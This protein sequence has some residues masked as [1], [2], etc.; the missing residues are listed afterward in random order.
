MGR[1]LLVPLLAY[2]GCG[3]PLA[4]AGP[5]W[6]IGQIATRYEAFYPAAGDPRPGQDAGLLRPRFGLPAIAQ[7][8]ASFTIELLERG[9]PIVAHAALLRPDVSSADAERCLAGT[10][11]DGCHPLNLRPD[12]SRRLDGLSVTR[13]RAQATAPPGG[14]DLYLHPRCDAPTRAPRA[15]WLRTEDPARLARVRVVQLSD[16]HI[17][18]H[19]PLVEQ[20]LRQVIGEVNALAP[21]LVVVTGDIVNQGTD[22]TLPPHARQLLERISAPVAIVLGNH[23]IGFHTWVGARYGAGWEN[24]ARSFHPFLEFELSLGGYRFVG[25]D[26]GATTL[27][28][29]IM[30]R[31]LSP[32]TLTRLRRALETAAQEGAR[33]VVLFSHAPSRAVLSGRVSAAHG[34]L[35]G[36][37]RDGRRTFEQLLLRSA[38]QGERVL[39]LAGHTHWSDVFEAAPRGGRLAFVR[40]P[41][42]RGDGELTPIRSRAAMVTTQAATHAGARVKAS[43]RGYGFTYLVLGQG[44][45]QIAFFRHDG[46]AAP[47]AAEHD[48][49]A[50]GE[51]GR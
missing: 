17:G 42:G 49:L 24:F 48:A 20:R 25:F 45:P 35:F 12:S 36:H 46:A 5:D 37:M 10:A 6:V 15:V 3:A 23:D 8:G 47:V 51:A 11:V 18:K 43:A 32:D 31:G 33:G 22:P 19:V 40:W 28:P 9:G 1:M 50:R 2:A 29:R 27:S 21:D 16:L 41:N 30:T 4:T 34:G 38:A 7:A 39:H 14:Y 26:S 44:D 13:L